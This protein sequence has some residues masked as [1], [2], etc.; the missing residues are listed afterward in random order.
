[1]NREAIVVPLIQDNGLKAGV[2]ESSKKIEVLKKQM[3][4]L[5]AIITK[6]PNLN[7]ANYLLFLPQRIKQPFFFFS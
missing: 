2:A 6:L 1:M 7:E 4:E 3:G 5:E